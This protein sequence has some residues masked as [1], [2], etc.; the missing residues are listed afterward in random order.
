MTRCKICGLILDEK[1]KAQG[2]EE[3]CV[4]CLGVNG[5]PDKKNRVRE[6][7]LEFWDTVNRR[8]AEPAPVPGDP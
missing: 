2:T 3:Y 5:K 6:S 8:A 1:T 7:V 4:F